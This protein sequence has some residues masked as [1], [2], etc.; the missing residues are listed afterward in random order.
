MARPAAAAVAL[1]H[2]ELVIAT[3]VAPL[4]AWPG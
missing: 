2:G 4:D 3:A 1:T